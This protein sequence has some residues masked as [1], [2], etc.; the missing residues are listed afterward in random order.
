MD[1]ANPVSFKPGNPIIR[2][3]LRAVQISVQTPI[4]GERERY[5]SLFTHKR[6]CVSS[7]PPTPRWKM[8]SNS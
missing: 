6:N 7:S 8:T 5:E 2:S 4:G 1:K 3:K